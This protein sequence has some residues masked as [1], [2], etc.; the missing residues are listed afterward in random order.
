MIAISLS[1]GICSNKLST[2]QP[3][4]NLISS[5][6]KYLKET[7]K[8]IKGK[9]I[10]IFDTTDAL[11]F[12]SFREEIQLH[13]PDITSQVMDS[14]EHN[15]IPQKIDCDSKENNPKIEVVFSNIYKN[16]IL[17]E[18]FYVDNS[19]S[20]NDI[21]DMRRFKEAKSYLI[22]FGKEYEIKKVYTKTVQYE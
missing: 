17:C 18:W 3:S 13:Y 15:V 7:E 19:K 21:N 8:E 16:I 20:K 1:S 4:C 9:E 6:I 10:A 12:A 2:R 22:E 5:V 14:L 11:S